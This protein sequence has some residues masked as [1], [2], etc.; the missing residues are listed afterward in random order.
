VAL[1]KNIQLKYTRSS[2]EY[3]I[4]KAFWLFHTKTVIDI[5]NNHQNMYASINQNNNKDEIVSTSS[6]PAPS[7]VT[8]IS[9]NRP[10]TN[11]LTDLLSAQKQHLRHIQRRNSIGD[12][13]DTGNKPAAKTPAPM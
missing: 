6:Q 4:V 9:N 7:T 12:L 8:P 10:L 2:V 5:I 11:S 13:R 1:E 3:S